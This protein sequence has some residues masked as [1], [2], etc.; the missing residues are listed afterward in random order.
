MIGELR[1]R[2]EAP[3]V[4]VAIGFDTA[5]N[6]LEAGADHWLP[7]PFVPGALVGAVRAVLRKSQSPVI[8]PAVSYE[9]SGMELDG[10]SRTLTFQGRQAT[11]TRQEW[12]LMV[13]LVDHPNRYLTAREILA[14]GWRAGAY[15]PEEVRIYVRRLCRKMEP[16]VL[17]CE[18]LSK[19]GSGYCLKFAA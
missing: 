11:F 3:L 16:L 12:Q 7:K 15:G 13:I 8:P 5:Q 2:T 6:D 18:L 17:P 14:L 9:R 1:L 19:H 10:G 4:V